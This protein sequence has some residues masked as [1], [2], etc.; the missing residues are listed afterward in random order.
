M[1]PILY[2][3]DEPALLEVTKIS[4]ETGGE[5]AVDTCLSAEEA[6]H[7]LGSVSYEAII[8]DY[9]MPGMDG[10]R[11]LK[12]L[13]E[14]FP[15]MPFILFTGKGREEVA[16]EALNSG[17]DFYVQKGGEPKSQ[18]AELKNKVTQLVR[19][20]AAE[21]ALAESQEKYRD[22]VENLNEVPY[23]I[24]TAG[25]IRYI[26]PMV[27]Q[28][29][30]T[31]EEVTGRP[32]MDFVV[33]E[34]RFDIIRRMEGIRDGDAKPYVFRIR[35]RDG[36]VIWI[37]GSSR[38]FYEN[39]RF[40]G[41]RGVMTDFTARKYMEEALEESEGHYR[42][43]FDNAPMGIFHSAAEGELLDVNPALARM[44]GY[45]SPEDVVTTVNRDGGTATLYAEPD[46]RPDFIRMAK[47]TGGWVNTEVRFRKKDGNVFTASMT[48]RQFRDRDGRAEL[49]GFVVDITESRKAQARIAASERRYRN[50]FESAGDA[51]LVIDGR[52]GDILD[53]NRAALVLYRYALEEIRGMKFPDLL[54]PAPDQASVS[55]GGFDPAQYHRKK[56]G[57]V[58]P[59]EVTESTYPQ[60][61]RTISIMSIRDVTSRKEAEDRV[62][63]T[64][65]MYV[66]L[67]RVSAAIVRVRDLETLLREICRIAVEDGHF[68]MAW[69]GL[70]DREKQL[71]SPVAHAGYED[72]Y[73]AALRIPLDASPEGNGPTGSAFRSG[74]HIITSDI[75]TD[76]RM[77]PW[78]GE[79]IQRGY[80]SSAAFPFSLHGEVVGVINLYAAEPGFFTETE[81]ALM[82]EIADDVSFALGLLDEQ[83]RR[84]RA[85]KALAGSEEHARFL[86]GILGMSSQP[87]YVGYADGRFGIV[88]PAFCDLLGYSETEIRALTWKDLTPPE[89]SEPE[90]KELAGLISTGIPRR[91]EKEFLRKDKTRVP[92]E[93]FA[94]RTVDSGGNLRYFY[95]FVTDISERRQILAASATARRE[96]ETIFSAIGNPAVILDPSRTILEANDTILRL[97]GKTRDE[98]RTMKC[99][100]VFHGPRCTGPPEG[101]PFTRMRETGR[102]ETASIEVQVFGGTYLISCT[103]VTDDAGNLERV[104]H[105][106]TDITPL[107]RAEQAMSDS[108]ARYR[109]IFEKSTDAVILMNGTIL[110]CNPAAE[111]LWGLRRE[112]IIG[113]DHAEFSPPVQPDGTVSAE[114]AATY[115]L[116]A[117]EWGTQFFPWQYRNSDGRLLDTDV[118]L[119]SVTVGGERRL[120]AIIRDVTARRHAEEEI[121][122][123][124]QTLRLITDSVS[125]M[126]WLMDLNLTPVFINPSV[127]RLRGYTLE[128]L[129]QV[130]LVNR[131]SPESA[132]IV[133]SMRDD[134]VQKAHT[135]GKAPDP[136]TVDLEFCKKDGSTFWS[137]NIFS[138]IC[139]D[140]GRP[141]RILGVGRDITERKQL[142][143]QIRRLASFPELNPEPVIEINQN[144]EITYANPACLTWLENLKMPGNPAAFLPKDIA[145]IARSLKESPSGFITREVTVGEAVF[146]ESLTLSPGGRAVRIYAHDITSRFRENG[147]LTRANRKLHLLSGITRHDIRNRLTAVL[148]YLELAKSSTSDATLLEYLSRTE[149]AAVAIRH[150]IEYTKEYE[151]LGS[152]VPRW[153]DISSLIDSASGQFDLHG[154]RLENDVEG[155]MIYAD[156]MIGR[157]IHHLIDNALRHGGPSLTRIRFSGSVTPGGYVLVCENDGA[158]IAKKDKAAIFRRVV[159]GD[160]KMGLFLMQEILALTLITVRETGDPEKGARFEMT[161]P[162]G[163]YRITGDTNEELFENPG[164]I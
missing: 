72:G 69:V 120:I 65:R 82:T 2:V 98:L 59:V 24:D 45:D 116:A 136:V 89:F 87:F 22:L 50:V 52:T 134:L 17:A 11:F 139:D 146:E 164:G 6:L 84:A 68:R 71:I 132:A 58:F 145:E 9:Q 46:K 3:D 48:F 64:R 31:A 47:E 115:T 101:C 10:L 28:F 8:S 43:I 105:I 27:R 122:K 112:Q 138:L 160:T 85:E 163:A 113:H 93:I 161:V 86:A 88:N 155:V 103:P 153:Q 36:K 99:W 125:D 5:F 159:T 148:G 16:I 55:K 117:Y 13:R 79:A 29:G 37:S 157:V 21:K 119:S 142:E 127:A 123:S 151:N 137:E 81:V 126:V 80:R 15:H 61:N 109:T 18:F 77:E 62:L 34:D 30:Y 20:R 74:V 39:G 66:V 26:S 162:P 25:I 56:D 111:R 107:K 70:I 91:Y 19:R 32:V 33:A 150:Q 41:I 73:L 147:A 49:E 57:V 60:K 83:A 118:S 110:D 23:I 156:P 51:M 53:A 128:E 106:A 42:G 129:E 140:E 131:L 67:S 38:P 92:V 4:L 90:E 141:V 108:E 114:A 75:A 35:S 152:S 144:R 12:V 1:I 63:A 7:R 130:P 14:R 102:L 133:L 40:A 96:W 78:R 149:I 44:F 97:T 135:T 121:E 124:E 104:I 143:N 54:A 154:T 158:G 94:H 76:P 100:Q 95:S